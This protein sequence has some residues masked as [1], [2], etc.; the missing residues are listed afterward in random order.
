MR[1]IAITGRMAAGKTTISD[2]LVNRH[3]YTR[4]SFAGR[5][6]DIAAQVYGGGLPVEK[7][8]TYLVT[9]E[10]TGQPREL[11]GREILQQLG[12]S[13]KSFDRDLWVRWLLADIAGRQGAMVAT[14]PPYVLDD[15]RFDYEAEALKAAGWMVVKVITPR[16]VRHERYA[17]LYGS[18]PSES[19]ENHP[20]EVGVD[21]IRE[22]Y[23]ILGD[24]NTTDDVL[25]MLDVSEGW[26]SPHLKV[27]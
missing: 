14:E 23:V 25:D 2:E 3:G 26:C 27:S 24:G 16:E 4:A 11:L 17:R 18:Y 21:D 20:S 13:V 22:H 19:M 5:L 12:Q 1:N 8:L 15:L 10:Q 9:D 7:G 6:K